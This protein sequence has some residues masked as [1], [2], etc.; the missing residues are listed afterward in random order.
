MSGFRGFGL[1]VLHGEDLL[2]ILQRCQACTPRVV[3]LGLGT[4]LRD[5]RGLHW[6]I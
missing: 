4:P 2:P 1:R 5:A 3:P 6:L